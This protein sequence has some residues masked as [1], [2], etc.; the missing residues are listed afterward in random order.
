MTVM[1]FR[2]LPLCMPLAVVSLMYAGYVQT[3][4]K[5]V[6]SLVLPVTDGMLGVTLCSLVLI[7]LAGMNGLYLSNIL[8]GLIC[9]AVMLLAPAPA[10][11]R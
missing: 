4:E 10:W 8:N 3:A 7:P 5:K 11:L 6:M 9:A 1:G 2:L